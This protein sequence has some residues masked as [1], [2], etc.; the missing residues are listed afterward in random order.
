MIEDE[1][2]IRAIVDS[3]GDEGPRLVYADWLEERSDPRASYVRAEHAWSQSRK[4]YAPKKVR[5]LAEPLEP[6]WV[7]RVSRPPVG[8]CVEAPLFRKAPT[9]TT[10]RA[11]RK[12]ES[13]FGVEFHVDYTAFLLNYNGGGFLYPPF[14]K[15]GDIDENAFTDFFAGIGLSK[16]DSLN[17]EHF[18]NLIL[19]GEEEEYRQ[20][21][22][23]PIGGPDQ[24]R[25]LYLLG[26]GSAGFGPGKFFGQVYGLDQS[27]QGC[28]TDDSGDPEAEVPWRWREA[29]SFSKLLEQLAAS[30]SDDPFTH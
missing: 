9:P 18:A 20:A 10:A 8:V 11:I 24:E 28:P 14:G 5:K 21:G 13:A 25:I 26:V 27:L 15:D 6:L 30:R 2:F 3:P 7:A 1:A 19:E 17:L 12:L 4:P 22:L 29:D 16:R 23:F